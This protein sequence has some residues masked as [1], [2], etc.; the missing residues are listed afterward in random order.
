MQRCEAQLKRILQRLG[1]RLDIREIR[2]YHMHLPWVDVIGHPVHGRRVR[3]HR[4]IGCISAGL[5]FHAGLVEGGGKFA[6]VVA[7]QVGA[8]IGK[9]AAAID[10]ANGRGV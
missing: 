1:L 3:F 7:L 2:L 9:W 10:D 4:E 6:G 5:K 8:G